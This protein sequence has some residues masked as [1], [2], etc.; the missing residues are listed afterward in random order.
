MKAKSAAASPDEQREVTRSGNPLHAEYPGGLAQRDQRPLKRRD[1]WDDAANVPAGAA[2]AGWLPIPEFRYLP[3][4]NTVAGIAASIRPASFRMRGSAHY[5]PGAIPRQF[6]ERKNV[7]NIRI[8]A[9]MLVMSVIGLL[10]TPGAAQFGMPPFDYR[11]YPPIIHRVPFHAQETMVWCWVASAKMVAEFHARKPVPP[12][13]E[14]LQLAYGAPCCG[15][16]DVCSRAGHISEIQGLIQRFGGRVSGVSPPANGFVLYNALKRGPIV[17]H[18]RQGA[19][20]FVVAVG[21]RVIPTQ[22]G[23][24]GVVAINDPF[25]G[26][27]ELDFPSLMQIWD[28]A[29]VVY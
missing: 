1:P 26:Q 5:F 9:V 28:A 11:S 20:H 19:G 14:M 10:V 16:P 4:L 23:P 21:M 6:T 25:V 12:Q 7:M 8:P 17:M 3:N 18:T 29:L 22:F 15:N 13:C 2:W 24:L 27:Y